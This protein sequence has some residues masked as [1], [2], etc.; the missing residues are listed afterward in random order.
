MNGRFSIDNR[1]QD[2]SLEQFKE[3]AERLESSLRL[4]MP[5]IQSGLFLT[6]KREDYLTYVDFKFSAPELWEAMKR[7]ER[8]Q[9]SDLNENLWNISY[10][11][12]LLITESSV[13]EPYLI[14]LG[15]EC[16]EPKRLF[17]YG[18]FLDEK[19]Q[20]VLESF[21]KNG[22][23]HKVGNGLKRQPD[24]FDGYRASNLSA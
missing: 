4:A 1:L 12:Q 13:K 8:I 24:L 3:T 2:V 21:R 14:L 7:R 22:L 19:S 20:E 16:R 6:T 15:N 9:L 17:F 23:L 18:Q 10:M 11:A 5:K